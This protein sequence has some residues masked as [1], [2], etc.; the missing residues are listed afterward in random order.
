M[1]ILSDNHSCII[2]GSIENCHILS[3]ENRAHVFIKHDIFIPK[4]ARCCNC[5]LNASELLTATS[6]TQI[7]HVNRPY[8]FSGVELGEFLQGLRENAMESTV[9]CEENLTEAD[10]QI[11]TPITKDQFEDL[12]TFCD[13][14]PIENTRSHRKVYRK[15]L[16]A[17]LLK[18]HQGISDDLLKI[19]FKYS[20]RQSVSMAIATV[21]KS[22]MQRFVLGTYCTCIQGART[23]GTCAHVV[24]VIWFL[25]FARHDESTRYPPTTL[26]RAVQDAANRPVP[27]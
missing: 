24:S 12:F 20:S 27:Q 14:V 25:A 6:I 22:L 19:L 7:R 21:R 17:F 3:V 15:D 4:G 8:I 13:R 26:L 11:V 23:I 2:C 16:L 5:H 10:F 18:L 9:L 1:T